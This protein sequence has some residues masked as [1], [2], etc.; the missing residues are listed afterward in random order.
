M[1]TLKERSDPNLLVRRNC[2]EVFFYFGQGGKVGLYGSKNSSN[3]SM[4]YDKLHCKRKQN[5]FSRIFGIQGQTDI[6]PVYD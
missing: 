6:H 4:D 5:R 3:P 2:K 1:V